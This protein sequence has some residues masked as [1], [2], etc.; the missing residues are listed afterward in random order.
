MPMSSMPPFP[1]QGSF[2]HAPTGGPSGGGQ[3][4]GGPPPPA[5]APYVLPN[6]VHQLPWVPLTFSNAWSQGIEVL[7]AQY[8]MLL[9]S[10]GIAIGVQF[11]QTMLGQIL[12]LVG[13]LIDPSVVIVVSVLFSLIMTIL[14]TW[15][16]QVCTQYVSIAA[17]RGEQISMRL[18]F[19]GYYRLGNAILT[20]FLT[21]MIVAACAIPCVL[22]IVPMVIMVQSNQIAPEISVP[23][24]ILAAL[25]NGVGIGYVASRLALASAMCV[26]ARLGDLTATQSIKM[27]WEWTRNRGWLIMGVLITAGLAMAATV[28]IL[29]VGY[30]L[31]GI[32]LAMAIFGAMYHQLGFEQGVFPTR[33]V[34]P[35]CNYDLSGVN[36]ITCPECGSNVAGYTTAN[37]HA[38]DGV[39]PTSFN[40]PPSGPSHQGP[41]GSTPPPEPPPQD[42]FGQ[43]P[44]APRNPQDPFGGDRS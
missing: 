34:C 37:T 7:K 11:A 18:L 1:P 26:D 33:Q 44:D 19:R 23:I 43:D 31:L 6:A 28:M 29:C 36:A 20:P 38:H 5:A 3:S 24:C 40:S 42:P 25:I 27:S 8:G 14:V 16:I 2:G 21:T 35:V 30:I 41:A 13:G 39:P 10:T 9:A 32:P 15:P 22:I 17:R 4:T 12:G